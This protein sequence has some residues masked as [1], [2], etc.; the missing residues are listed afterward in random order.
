MLNE[1]SINIDRKEREEIKKN[2][3]KVQKNKTVDMGEISH[4]EFKGESLEILS[5]P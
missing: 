3:E 2:L 5:F 4:K 1:I